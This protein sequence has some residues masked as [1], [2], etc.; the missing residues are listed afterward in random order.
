VRVREG[1]QRFLPR[2]WCWYQQRL[3]EVSE[4]GRE[5]RVEPDEEWGCQVD[6]QLVR[7]TWSPRWRRQQ[8]LPQALRRRR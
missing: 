3:G 8:P 5:E 1:A 4:C 7:D 2:Y 6:R